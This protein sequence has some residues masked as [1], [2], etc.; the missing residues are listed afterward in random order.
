VRRSF[1]HGIGRLATNASWL[2]GGEI[3]SKVASFALI[4]ILARGLGGR[5]FGYF[6]FAIS[7][8]P[9]F[10]MFGS[11]GIDAALIREL[12]RDH[13][14]LSAFFSSGL[15]LRSV[16]GLAALLL[17]VALA[18]LLVEGM[19]ALA[20]I[21]LVGVALLFDELSRF[22]GAVFKAFER[23]KFHAFVLVINRF[24]STGLAGIALLAGGGFVLVS[25]AYAAGSIGGLVF[26]WAMLRRRFPPI[27]LGDAARSI[28]GNLWRAGLPLGLASFLNMAVF[29]MDSVL[30]QALRGP[31]QVAMYGI[32]YRFFES[33]LFVAWALGSALLPRVA[34]LG[35]GRASGRTVE[36]AVAAAL[37]IY[38]PLAAGAPFAAQWIITGLFSDRYAPA[39]SAVY[40]LTGAAIFY[41][42]AH[43]AR[44][45]V[46]GLGQRGAVA[47][48]ALVALVFNIALNIVVIPRY[49]FAG[50]AA[51]T[52]ATEVLEAGLL[53]G[54][55]YRVNQGLALGSVVAVPVVATAV[56][57]AVLWVTGLRDGWAL[58]IGATTYVAS[59]AGGARLL[60]P[61]DSLQALSLFRRKAQA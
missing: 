50:A 11:W 15:L 1:D 10:L 40:W 42:M 36:V 53:L 5:E 8:F 39:A 51:A 38:L 61:R 23:M 9:L 37:A 12:S 7:F 60:A 32:S 14:R 59:L 48:V 6:V 45:A 2:I 43:L 29:R 35:P 21:S 30:L 24:V 25:G 56:M 28:V 22:I 16:L 17:A 31:V 47:R 55:L 27:R 34:R 49:G 26:A 13:A 58:G 3:I 19:G 54:L 41:A 4:V 33:F 18:P 57:V 44:M 46:V 20:G 52:F